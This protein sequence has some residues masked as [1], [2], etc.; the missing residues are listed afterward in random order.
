MKK[1]IKSIIRCCGLDLVTYRPFLEL[2]LDWK[3]QYVL[4]IGANEGQF[5]TELR[6][7]GFKGHIFSFEPV[8]QTFIRLDRNAAKDPLWHTYN[9]ALGNIRDAMEIKI[10]DDSQLVSL[11]DPVRIHKFTDTTKI[12][13]QRLVDWQAP[14]S[15]AWE[16]ACLKIDTQ[17]YEMQVLLGAEPI[18]KNLKAIIAELA[19]NLS[20]KGQPHAEDV[21]GFLR[22]RSFDLWT[23]RRGTWTPHGCQEIERDGLFKNQNL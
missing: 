13:I 3:I 10:S 7:I 19:I 4:D 2:L 15:I 14:V 9:F 20:Y 21:V 12:Q 8:P 22:A 1:I 23:T 17:G 16:K 18:L 5:A 6:R 11:M